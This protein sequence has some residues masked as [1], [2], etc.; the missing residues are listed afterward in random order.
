MDADPVSAP[1]PTNPSD[2]RT[3]SPYPLPHN[4]GELW[5]GAAKLVVPVT[6]RATLR[7]LG[8]HTEGQRL[9]YDPAYKYDSEFAP[10]QRLRGDM[11]SDHLQYISNPRSSLPVVLDFRGGRY[12]REFL[13]GELV[14]QPDYALGA[15][16]ASRF[17]FIGEDW[18][19]DLST[20]TDPIPGFHEPAASARTPWGV[21]AFF[22]GSGSKGETRAEFPLD[23]DQR[24]TLTAM[25][26]DQAG[27]R[28]PSPRSSWR[29]KPTRPTPRRSPFESERYRP[30]SGSGRGRLR[31]G[32]GRAIPDVSRGGERLRP[33]DF[34]Y[35]PPR[36]MRLGMELPF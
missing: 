3:S 10:G 32:A 34:A 15:L 35:G 9:L 36:L 30:G 1:A 14:E 20:S 16:T 8:L 19:K 2:P 22:M 28:P 29:R 27:L 12:A 31:G 24:H 17:H 4:S 13:R 25:R 21:P 7:A 33:A 11:V 23:F 18:A 26:R 6:A 5:S